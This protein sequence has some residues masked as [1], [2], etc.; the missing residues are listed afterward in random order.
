VEKWEVVYCANAAGTM[1][2]TT[3]TSGDEIAEL[4]CAESERQTQEASVTLRDISISDGIMNGVPVAVAMRSR[5]AAGNNGPL[6]NARIQTPQETTDFWELY[7]GLGGEEDGGFCFVATAAH[8]SYAHPVVRALRLFRDRVMRTSSAGTGLVMAYY[9]WSPPAADALR[10]DPDAAWYARIA[11]LPISFFALLW[12]LLPLLGL[13]AIAWL[14]I[15][16]LGCKAGL[17][18]IL[19]LV[20]GLAKAETR[21]DATGLIGFGVEFK[22]GPYLPDMSVDQSNQ[23]FHEIFGA[24]GS[25]LLFTLGVEV[26]LFRAF[27]TVAVGGNFGFMQWVGKGV[28]GTS[29]SKS[30]DTTVL[31]ILP[32]NLVAI[33]RFDWLAD[34]YPVPLV[35]YVKG[36]LAYYFWWVTTSTG[37]ISRFEGGDGTEDDQAGRGGKI[38]FTGTAGIAIMLN[39]IETTAAQSLYTATGIRG[40]YLFAEVQ[41]AKVNGFGG[42]GFDFSEV[43]WNVGMF[44]EF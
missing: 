38:G 16:K 24:Q 4:P 20:P 13:A 14:L 17:I 10:A 43:T 36:G 29:S 35:P 42:N 44:L 25:N 28:F 37:D 22:G 23:A 21:P 18:L 11:L 12:T 41:A 2:T 30:G 15:R 26:Q 19:L 27:G 7:K 8:G 34:N 31:N 32:T 6:S 3:S 5:D 1:T 40:T 39:H 33:Y 9:R